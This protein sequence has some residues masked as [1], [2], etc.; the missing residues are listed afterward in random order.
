[1]QRTK[2]QLASRAGYRCSFPGCDSLTVGPSDESAE[3]ISN[4]GH[5]CHITAAADGPGARRYDPDLSPE[6]RRSINNGIW[7]CGRHAIEIDRDEDRFTVEKLQHWKKIAE[8][9]ARLSQSFGLDFVQE[10]PHLFFN[11][12]VPCHLSVRLEQI[13]GINDSIGNA[14]FDSSLPSVWGKQQAIVI[15]DLIVEITRNGFEHGEATSFDMAISTDRIEL[16]YDG[17]PFNIFRLLNTDS[18]GGGS[19]ILKEFIGEHKD[20]VAISYHY[21]SKNKIIIHTVKELQSGDSILPCVVNI[22]LNSIDLVPSELDVYDTCGALYIVL[23]EHFVYSDV[24]EVENTLSDIKFDG[25]PVFIV[26]RDLSKST[27]RVLVEKFPH[28]S[29]VHKIS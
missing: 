15:R 14:I 5:A 19:E 20:I 25:K 3:S 27:I 11:R 4:V 18:G 8:E 23:P 12:L 26:G 6:E 24:K 7:M 17:N 2:V 10:N 9:R 21:D 29:L 13:S 22:D 16:E 1:M 28:L